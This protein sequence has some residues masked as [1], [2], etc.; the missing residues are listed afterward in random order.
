MKWTD[1][2][3]PQDQ[4]EQVIT[5]GQARMQNYYD[6]RHH[7]GVKYKSSKKQAK[8]R[9]RPLQVLEVLPG[10]TYRVAELATDSKMLQEVEEVGGEFEDED[11]SQ[12]KT[13]EENAN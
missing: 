12:I 5:K 7:P 1:P 11:R 2:G 3:E 4:I 9:E 10:D 6:Q 8:Y 13:Q